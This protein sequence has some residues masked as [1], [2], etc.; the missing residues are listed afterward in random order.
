MTHHK[1]VVSF[2]G[3]LPGAI[4]NTI[5]DVSLKYVTEYTLAVIN[6]VYKDGEIS[7][8]EFAEQVTYYNT[9]NEDIKKIVTEVLS[10]YSWIHISY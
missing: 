4:E 10:V 2:Y 6:T 8:K 5:K 3:T 9:N 7:Y 1:N